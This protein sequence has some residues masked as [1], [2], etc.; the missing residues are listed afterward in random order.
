[1]VGECTAALEHAEVL[2]VG[3]ATKALLPGIVAGIRPDQIVVDLV[4]L[5]R[6]QFN[7]AEYHGV[8]W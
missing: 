4:G 2:V 3:L 8:C 1:M 7:C 6:A 5:P